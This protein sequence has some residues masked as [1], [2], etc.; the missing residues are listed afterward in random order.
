LHGVLCGD[1][2]GEAAANGALVVGDE[3]A[4]H[5]PARV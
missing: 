1:Q 5:A 3:N 4:D 2:R